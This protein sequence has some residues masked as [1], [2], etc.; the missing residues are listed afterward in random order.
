M[1]LDTAL[2]YMRRSYRN[3]RLGHAYLVLGDPRGVGARFAERLAQLLFCEVPDGPC[4]TCTT[5]RKIDEARFEDLLTVE[6]EKKSRIFSVDTIRDTILPWCYRASFRGGWKQLVLRFADCFN[7]SSGNALLKALEEPPPRTLM[8]LLTDRPEQLLPTIRSRC[9]QVDLTSGRQPPPE[10]WRSAVG[11]ILTAHRPS[12]E[13]GAF[14]TASRLE[15]LLG[16]I[17][18]EARRLVKAEASETEIEETKET[19]EAREGAKERELR[20]AVLHAMED[21][22]RDLLVLR[23]DGAS[24]SLH[25]GEHH[26]ELERRAATVTPRQAIGCVGII[27][28]LDRQLNDRH[29]RSDLV[30]PYWVARLA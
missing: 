13:L 29:I 27:R 18:K 17:K 6:P 28:D 2:E 22:Y 24:T 12:T 20:R 26:E 30:L 19:I 7:A 23:T 10:P 9:Q 1:T 25:F 8:L 4:G 15:A 14:A 3:D 5:C 11:Q 16:E 21:W